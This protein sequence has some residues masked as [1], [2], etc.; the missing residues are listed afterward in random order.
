MMESR[1]LF[2]RAGI[3]LKGGFDLGR[4]YYSEKLNANLLFQAY[5]TA[6]PQVRDYLEGTTLDRLV[7]PRPT[8]RPA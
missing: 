3:N 6:I 7:E 5:D 2:D 8:A 4:D 1:R